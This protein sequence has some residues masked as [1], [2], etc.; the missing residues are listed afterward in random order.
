MTSAGT[1]PHRLSILTT[2]CGSTGSDDRCPG[3]APRRRRRRNRD[4]AQQGRLRFNLDGDYHRHSKPTPLSLS[5][6]AQVAAHPNNVV[7]P[8]LCSPLPD[9]EAVFTGSGRQFHVSASSPFA[10]LDPGTTS[11]QVLAISCLVSPATAAAAVARMGTGLSNPP[12]ST[13]RARRSMWAGS[14][15][16]RAAWSAR[17]PSTRR[18]ARTS[19]RT[20]PGRSSARSECWGLETAVD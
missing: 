19:M 5:I 6:P 2:S 14:R 15:R 12:T 16:E 17:S 7:T 4:A 18:R 3:R 9:N 1:P 11:G 8:W 10:F 20:P 13:C